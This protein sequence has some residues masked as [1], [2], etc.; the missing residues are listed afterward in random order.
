MTQDGVTGC[1]GGTAA[2]CPPEPPLWLSRLRT[3]W[4]T[5]AP[6]KAPPGGEGNTVGP[7]AHCFSLALAESISVCVCV[8]GHMLKVGLK[9]ETRRDRGESGGAPNCEPMLDGKLKLNRKF[10]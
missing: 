7:P 3:H 1:R 6:S 10:Y 2:C 9:G 5:L 4:L 8:R